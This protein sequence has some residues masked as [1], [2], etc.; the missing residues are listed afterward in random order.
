M[1]TT[2]SINTN[3]HKVISSGTIIGFSNSPN[4]TFNISNSSFSFQLKLTFLLDDSQK[5]QVIS[6]TI[7]DGN[8]IELKCFNFTNTL[9]SGTTTPINLATLNGK[10]IYFR[11][12]AHD[13]TSLPRL[14]YTFYEE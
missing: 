9:G 14:T 11:F 10:K 6:S 1:E 12:I 3:N 13:M 8:V 2:I 7:L 5:D 4:F